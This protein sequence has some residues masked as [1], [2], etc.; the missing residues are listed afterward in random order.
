MTN[1]AAIAPDP[2]T[3]VT[4]FGE[5]SGGNRPLDAFSYYSL[6]AWPQFGLIPELIMTPEFTE[7]AI[8]V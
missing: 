3:N 8:T 4:L 5:A 6:G 7:T 2:S 1:T